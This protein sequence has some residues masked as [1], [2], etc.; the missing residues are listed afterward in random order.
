MLT[1]STSS[2]LSQHDPLCETVNHNV[3]TNVSVTQTRLT[4]A[5]DTCYKQATEF[6]WQHKN[7]KMVVGENKDNVRE[8]LREDTALSRD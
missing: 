3:I 2:T 5:M 1:V 6:L 4:P 8:K 7:I